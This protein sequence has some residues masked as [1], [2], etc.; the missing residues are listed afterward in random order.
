MPPKKSKSKVNKKLLLRKFV[1]VPVKGTRLFYMKEMTLLNSL[2][3]R[4]SEEFVCVLKFPKNYDSMAVI[5]C[6]SYKKEIDKKFRDF[7]Y[8]IDETKYEEITLSEVKS[9]EDFT[10]VSKPKTIKKF[11]NG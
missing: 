9:G 7:N 2:I 1:N 5:L 3:E 4:Y 11:L 8:K 10:L 6:E